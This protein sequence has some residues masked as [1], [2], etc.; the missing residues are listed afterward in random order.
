M[1]GGA[2]I[3]LRP[4]YVKGG[5]NVLVALEEAIRVHKQ[6]GDL[7]CVFDV[8][9]CPKGDVTAAIQL[10]KSK[11]VRL[12]LSARSFEVW[13]A[14]H[15][16]KSDKPITTEAEAINLVAGHCQG[17]SVKN[18]V[19][20]FGE[21]LPRSSAACVNAAWLRKQAV[22][23]PATDVDELVTVLMGLLNA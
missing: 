22:S 12:C 1:L 15:F 20:P 7:W 3:A 17:Y 2:G 14:L 9:D 16:A 4:V 19:V 6:D 11:G 5:G 13:L 18:K 10:A 23:N 8:D 21:L